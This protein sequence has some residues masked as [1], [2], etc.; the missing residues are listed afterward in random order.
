MSLK[1]A[2]ETSPV[3]STEWAGGNDAEISQYIKQERIA[4]DKIQKKD[5]PQKPR[6]RASIACVSCRDRRIRVCL[7]QQFLL[8]IANISIVCGNAWPE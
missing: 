2:Q 3:N 1:T 7:F 5:R 8:L 4:P 6:Y